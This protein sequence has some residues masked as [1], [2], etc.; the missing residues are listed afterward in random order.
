MA[1]RCSCCGAWREQ[2]CRLCGAGA[3]PRVEFVC[4]NIQIEGRWALGLGF[5]VGPGG[6]LLQ[7]GPV[8]FGLLRPK[9]D[10]S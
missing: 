7:L 9:A 10:P 8:A 2:T 3:A 4:A 1:T 5:S 6:F